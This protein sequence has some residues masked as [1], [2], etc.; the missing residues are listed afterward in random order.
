MLVVGKQDKTNYKVLLVSAI[1][2]IGF[3]VW[4][5]FW[6]MLG[7]ALAPSPTDKQTWLAGG[8]WL[9]WAATFFTALLAWLL[10]VRSGYV[11]YASGL[12]LGVYF[13]AYHIQPRITA[14]GYSVQ[15]WLVP[16][17]IV[18]LLV[19]TVSP[20]RTTASTRLST[21]Q[22]GREEDMSLTVDLQDTKLLS[23]VNELDNVSIKN[24]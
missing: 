21:D 15:W 4:G 19:A 8:I 6:G 24:D 10:C 13:I 20:N 9:I 17:I 3:L 2:S 12:V 23:D 14:E 22:N 11:M 7:M 18:I 1:I 5:I 16:A